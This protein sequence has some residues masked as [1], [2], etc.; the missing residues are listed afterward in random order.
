MAGAI[1][2]HFGN[3]N[4]GAAEHG[5]TS[6]TAAG[7]LS[8]TGELHTD[9]GYSDFTQAIGKRVYVPNSNKDMDEDEAVTSRLKA[10]ELFLDRA[11]E[12]QESSKRAQSGTDT[13]EP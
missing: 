8:G 6:S 7:A 4:R 5:T 10:Y 13:S 1:R 11:F 12:A 3:G 2:G 9:F